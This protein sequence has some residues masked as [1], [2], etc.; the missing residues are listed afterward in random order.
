M[1]MRKIRHVNKPDTIYNPEGVDEL[2]ARQMARESDGFLIVK[3]N[4]NTTRIIITKKIR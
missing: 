1:D 3:E 4:R 2:V